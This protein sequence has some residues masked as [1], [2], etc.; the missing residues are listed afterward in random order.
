MDHVD[1]EMSGPAHSSVDIVEAADE[2]EEEALTRNI[3]RPT[4]AGSPYSLAMESSMDPMVG[5]SGNNL[6]RFH[7]LFFSSSTP[8][9]L[10]RTKGGMTVNRYGEPLVVVIE[11]GCLVDPEGD[12][13][14]EGWGKEGMTIPNDCAIRPS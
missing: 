11:E 10:S 6:P 1:G 14:G 2:V 12:E 13:T 4:V 9:G 5:C 8:P 3:S 7:L